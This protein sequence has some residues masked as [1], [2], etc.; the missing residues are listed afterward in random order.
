MKTKSITEEE[1]IEKYKEYKQREVFYKMNGKSTRNNI[2][3]SKFLKF[4]SNNTSEPFFSHAL[5]ILMND[6]DPDVR[7]AAA[8]DSL[9]NNYHRDFAIELLRKEANSEDYKLSSLT[10]EIVLDLNHISKR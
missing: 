9:R 5:Y 3:V 8:S 7:V 2:L 1:F 10:A 6:D 4:T